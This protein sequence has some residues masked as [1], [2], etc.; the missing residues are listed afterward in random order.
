LLHRGGT[1]GGEAA[2]VE[3]WVAFRAAELLDQP[4]R[5]GVGDVDVGGEQIPL[6]DEGEIVSVPR[7]RR[8]HVLLFA[9]LL[10]EADDR[11]SG[12]IRLGATGDLR[13]MHR[14]VRR[15]PLLWERR[16]T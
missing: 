10:A 9:Q 14:A 15:L 6:R 5:V 11:V 4:A 12:G 16:V 3:V 13:Q 2:R 8:R 1:R 7:P